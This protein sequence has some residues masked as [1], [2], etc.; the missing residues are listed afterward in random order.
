MGGR[1]CPPAPVC[2]CAG[3]PPHERGPVAP[4]SVR[5]APSP[6]RTT[7]R[8]R[9]RERR[10]RRRQKGMPRVR[11]ECREEGRDQRWR[12]P[13]RCGTERSPRCRGMGGG[14][15]LGAG[16]DGGD[17]PLALRGERHI[18]PLPR[19]GIRARG[20]RVPRNELRRGEVV[21]PQERASTVSRDR[22]GGASAQVWTAAT[23]PWR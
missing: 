8:C 7:T 21:P 23:H 10:M 6:G 5:P 11:R 17:A 2:T 14:W 18:L 22:G 16:V 3:P 13:L 19:C 15:S 12:H 20:D 4:S 1:V 9:G